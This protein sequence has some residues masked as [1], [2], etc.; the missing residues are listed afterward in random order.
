[1]KHKSHRWNNYINELMSLGKELDA[2]WKQAQCLDT[3]Y[4]LKTKRDKIWKMLRRALRRCGAILRDGNTKEIMEADSNNKKLFYTLIRRQHA[5]KQAIS[6]L[7]L[8]IVTDHFEKLVQPQ[9]EPNYDQ[10]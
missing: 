2:K 5:S 7:K 8:D 10:D 9:M 3:P 4:P 6:T 1:M